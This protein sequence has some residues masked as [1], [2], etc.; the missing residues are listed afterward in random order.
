[1]SGAF[2]LEDVRLF[3]ALGAQDRGGLVAF[4]LGDE[5][6]TGPLGG[7]LAGHGILDCGGRGDLPDLDRGDL[8]SP[9][10]GDLIEFGAQRF[11]DLVALRQHV[12]E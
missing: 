12:V 7:H 2:G 10:F 5:R 6:A 3:V 9:P 4:G 1:M 11:V 8:D